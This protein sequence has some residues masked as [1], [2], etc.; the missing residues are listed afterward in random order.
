MNRFGIVILLLAVTAIFS[1]SNTQPKT[2]A[3]EPD[4]PMVLIKTKYGNMKVVLYNETPQHRDNFLK[5]AREGYYDSLLFHRVIKGF[6]VQGG[7]PQ[8][9]NA[10]PGQQ[11][12]NGDPG[13]TIPAEITPKLLHKKGA[14]AA[15]RTGDQANPER[16]S[17]GSQFYIVQGEIIDSSKI[18]MM[19]GK[20]AQRAF[21]SLFARMMKAKSDSLEAFQKAN[22]REGFENLVARV[23]MEAADKITQYPPRL[24]EEQK[25][26][27]STIGGTPHLDGNYTVF[28]QVVEGLNVIDSIAAQPTAPGDRPLQDIRMAVEVL[29]EK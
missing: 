29:K 12:G 20:M 27:Y 7:D 14:L 2:A 9:K 3:S 17:S 19:E 11:L 16:R 8:S 10:L 22:N 13:Y 28:G 5:L 25:K 6:M 24:S 4:G 23:R 18:T 21:D 26:L 1:C 15:A